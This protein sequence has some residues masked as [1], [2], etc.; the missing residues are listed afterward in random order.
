MASEKL[1]G[2]LPEGVLVTADQV[3]FSAVDFVRECQQ[4]CDHV[5]QCDER[6]RDIL[7]GIY[8]NPIV[9]KYSR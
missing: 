4:F 5:D 7:L 6:Y 8:A 3:P 9:S 2:E 1:P